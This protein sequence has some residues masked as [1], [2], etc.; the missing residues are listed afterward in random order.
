MNHLISIIIFSLLSAMLTDGIGAGFITDVNYVFTITHMADHPPVQFPFDIV[1]DSSYRPIDSIAPRDIRFS[2]QFDTVYID[3]NEY[4]VKSAIETDWI[5]FDLTSSWGV[6]G[7]FVIWNNSMP[8]RA[9]LTRYGSGVPI[10]NSE[11]GILEPNLVRIESRQKSLC[12]RKSRH[13]ISSQKKF[14]INGR[15]IK[16][17]TNTRKVVRKN[18]SLYIR[19]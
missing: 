18:G 1:A 8:L 3:T 4:G 12:E 15:I 10:I 2:T 14:F 9:E 16:G 11:R 6:Y 5:Q 19:F 17:G 7:R 13:I